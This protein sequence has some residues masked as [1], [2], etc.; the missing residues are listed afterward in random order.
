MVVGRTSAGITWVE[1]VAVDDDD[2]MVVAAVL[3]WPH[4]QHA[5]RRKGRNSRPT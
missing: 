5:A 4:V 3:P 1:V 2:G